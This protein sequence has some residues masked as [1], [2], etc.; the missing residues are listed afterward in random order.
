MSSRSQSPERTLNRVVRA[1]VTVANAARR[2]RTRRRARRR[3]PTPPTSPPPTPSHSTPTQPT[4]L[5]PPSLSFPDQ[6]LLSTHSPAPQPQTETR[7]RH[8]LR[9]TLLSFPEH[10][11]STVT[12]LLNHYHGDTDRVIRKLSQARTASTSHPTTS[13]KLDPVLTPQHQ[14]HQQHQ[15]QHLQH[16][17]HQQRPAENILPTRPSPPP[18]HPSHRLR[19]SLRF[20][21]EAAAPLWAAA[22]RVAAN[23]DFSSPSPSP[24]TPNPAPTY[25]NHP[26]IARVAGS[27]RPRSSP[28]SS[29]TNLPSLASSP[30]FPLTPPTPPPI[31]SIPSRHSQPADT[32]PSQ[33]QNVLLLLRRVEQ[34]EAALSHFLTNSESTKT[35]VGRK[36]QS[37]QLDMGALER[38]HDALEHE[39]E[40]NRKR[41]SKTEQ[42]LDTMR[43]DVRYAIGGRES[44]FFVIIRQGTNG[45][46][47][48]LLAYLVPILFFIARAVRGA[49]ATVRRRVRGTE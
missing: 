35:D 3:S 45:L 21:R 15:Q 13:S 4:T 29:Q 7:R 31:P 24:S 34:L 46:L 38:R 48:Y 18:L 36:L 14:Q 2:R 12:A 33:T 5:N 49:I 10:D 39:L 19:P 16:Q 22:V 9:Q 40:D 32:T 27:K 8:D 37:A 17:Q 47:Y 41:V 25:Y 43:R 20:S 11:P 42:Y 1:G 26:R 28:A 23:S 30:E 44:R 6:L